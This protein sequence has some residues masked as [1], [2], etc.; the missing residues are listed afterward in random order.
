MNMTNNARKDLYGG[1]PA[2]V[3]L[4]RRGSPEHAA[5]IA[6]ELGLPPQPPPGS[7]PQPEPQPTGQLNQAPERHQRKCLV[8]E[9][10]CR[11]EIE[12]L[13]LQWHQPYSLAYQF[14][15]PSRSL[16]R[17]AHAAGLYEARQQ[18][19]HFVLD[20]FLER[21]QEAT[22]TGDSIIR[23]IRAYSCLTPNNK[24]IEH[25]TRVIYSSESKA[26]P[27]RRPK[28][29]TRKSRRLNRHSGD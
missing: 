1:R 17:H 23:A 18:N 11:E 20:R 16:Y 4:I 28:K 2:Q 3:Q 8:C 7:A 9:H 21:V 22:V 29:A 25:P 10:P 15:I 6:Q 14:E 19:L 5:S 12:E 27:S 24:W 26:A 13:F